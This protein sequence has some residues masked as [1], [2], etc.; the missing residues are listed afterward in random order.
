M[1]D[2]KMDAIR[3]N[4]FSCKSN[5][6][7]NK[8]NSSAYNR[9]LKLEQKNLNTIKTSRSNITVLDGL[10]L[11]ALNPS[12]YQNLLKKTATCIWDLN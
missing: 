12:N 10:Q 5:N 9:K 3:V 11:K 8:Y 1:M 6:N 7:N 4:K 2:R